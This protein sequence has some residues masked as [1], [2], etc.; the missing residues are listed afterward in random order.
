MALV[1]VDAENVRRST[2]PNLSREQLVERVREWAGRQ[3]HDV[4][5]VFDGTPPEEADDLLGSQN[6]DDAIVRLAPGLECPWWLVS[7]DRELRRRVGDGPER[8]L[9]GGSFLRDLLN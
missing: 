1:V 5:I 6:A 2:W 8:I 3:G 7:S 4:L 9:G